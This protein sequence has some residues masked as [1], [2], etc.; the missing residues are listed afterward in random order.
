MKKIKIIFDGQTETLLDEDESNLEEYSKVISSLFI[1]GNVN[2][3]QTT[4]ESLL[5]R[6]SKILAVKVTDEVIKSEEKKT[7]EIEDT[8]TD[9]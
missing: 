9:Q 5:V 3:I 8:I 1:S 2:I 7:E 4:N 6:P